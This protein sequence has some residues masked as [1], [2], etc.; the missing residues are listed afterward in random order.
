MFYH[1]SLGQVP[2]QGFHFIFSKLQVIQS[3]TIVPG[4]GYFLAQVLEKLKKNFSIYLMY[5]TIRVVMSG[6]NVSVVSR[7]YDKTVLVRVNSSY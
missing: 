6:Q 5:M 1:D 4:E 3:R 2:L 7:K